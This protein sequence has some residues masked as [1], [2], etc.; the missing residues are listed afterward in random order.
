MVL[1][2]NLKFYK[3]MQSNGLLRGRFRLVSPGFL[4]AVVVSLAMH[5]LLLVYFSKANVVLKVS[6][7]SN[8][9]PITVHILNSLANTLSA[10]DHPTQIARLEKSLVPVS[11]NQLADPEP[12]NPK[13]HPESPT[14]AV[15]VEQGVAASEQEPTVPAPA[16]P[17]PLPFVNTENLGFGDVPAMLFAQRRRGLFEPPSMGQ[18]QPSFYN[19]ES[20]ARWRYQAQSWGYTVQELML[21]LSALNMPK[22]DISCIIFDKTECINGGDDAFLNILKK[23]QG[24]FNYIDAS[25]KL[26]IFQ[27][28]NGWSIDGASNE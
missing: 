8:D 3:T 11:R 19:P 12:P 25:K 26:R 15:P 7:V 28:E 23:Y 24:R 27:S 17:L 6:R 22:Q 4:L 10:T 5:L 14:L 20:V 18:P 21:E 16:P 1:S 9:L 13:I 2:N